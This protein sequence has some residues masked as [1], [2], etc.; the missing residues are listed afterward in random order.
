MY[1]RKLQGQGCGWSFIA[2][3]GVRSTAELQSD[4]SPPV[5]HSE[6]GCGW[7]IP[8]PDITPGSEGAPEG[9]LTYQRCSVS[10][11]GGTCNRNNASEMAPI[12][13]ISLMLTT[14][15]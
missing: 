5:G 2:E 6:A 7:L 11:D 15:L 1:L 8:D 4:Q 10:I 3:E 12:C 14:I 9:F 13:L